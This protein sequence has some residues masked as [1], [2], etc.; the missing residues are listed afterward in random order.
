MQNET[1]DG[2]I[3]TTKGNV[4][5][6]AAELRRS[7]EGDFKYVVLSSWSMNSLLTA[8]DK[9]I[10]TQGNYMEPDAPD[11]LSLKMVNRSHKAFTRSSSVLLSASMAHALYGNEDPVGKVV[12]ID[13]SLSEKVVGV[14]EDFPQ[15]S[16]FKE[17]SFIAH[18]L[19]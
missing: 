17:V 18:F 3:I 5:P 6:L 9:K 10:N 4:L 7:Y 8:G 19:I 15:S 13:G 14:Y 16:S 11:M 2:Q 1:Y 12:K